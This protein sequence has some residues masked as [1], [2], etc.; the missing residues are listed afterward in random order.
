M[1]VI[2]S[3]L[4]Q[5]HRSCE[6]AENQRRLALWESRPFPIRGENQWHGVPA[7]DTDSGRPMP[8]TAECLDKIWEPVLG[9]EMGRYFTEPDYFLEY[10]LRMRLEKFRRFADDTPL[11]RDIPVCFGVTH[12]AGM[13]GQKVLF[14]HGEEPTFAKDPI[15]DESSELPGSFD[16]DRNEYLAM[17]IPFWRRVKELAGQEFNVLFPEWYRG[18]QGVALYIRGF[19]NFS[20]DLY[21]NPALAHRVLR[22]VTEAAKAYALWR[23][24]FLD[25]PL[26]KGDLFNDDLAIMSPQTYADFFLSYERELSDFYGGIAYWHSCGDVTPHVPEIHKLPDIDLLDFGV[27]MEDKA[28]GLAGLARPQA[29]EL[30]VF[31]KRHLQESSDQEAR[32]YVRGILRSCRQ[33]GAKRYVLRSSGMSLLLGAEKDLARLA[34]WVELVREAQVSE[35]P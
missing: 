9:L 4:D 33:A 24:R 32:D 17:V 30:R 16:F 31:A 25:Q 29:L 7:Y 12:E 19:E 1:S 27:T 14:T 34:R 21:L 2:A 22:Y 3:L 13:L 20:L 5:V 23:S 11:T 6:S 35:K 18:P 10:H 8:V 15:V 26:T 28:A